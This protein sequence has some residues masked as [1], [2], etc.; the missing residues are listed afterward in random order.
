[1]VGQESFGGFLAMFLILFVTTGIGNGSTFKM[2][3]VIFRVGRESAAVLGISSAIGALGGFFIPR[4]LGASIAAT[5]GVAGALLGFLVCYVVCI[6]VTWG[7]YLRPG[8]GGRAPPP[9]AEGPL[10]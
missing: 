1:F 2:V 4:I 7:G 3:P 8:D 5:G 6:G 9:G 10:N